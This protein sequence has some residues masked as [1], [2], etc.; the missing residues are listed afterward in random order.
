M[1]GRIV[2]AGVG[3]LLQVA[4]ALA[5]LPPPVRPM[6]VQPGPPI[7]NPGATA[8]NAPR[9]LPPGLMPAPP[10]VHP[11]PTTPGQPALP[12]GSVMR[13]N[14]EVPLPQREDKLPIDAGNLTLRR[15]NNTWQVWAGQRVFRDVGDNEAVGKEVIR[16]VRDL[17]PNE[18]V[19]IGG[20]RP[21]VEYGLIQGRPSVAAG[22]PQ[23]VVPIDLATARV[24]AVKGVWCLRDDDSILFNFGGKRTDADQAL[25]VVRKYGF[26]RIG[27]IGVGNAA[28][29]AM[30]YFF[31]GPPGEHFKPPLGSATAM[32]QEAS[33]TRTGI[34]VPGL[35]YV[36]E[37]V[38]IDPKKVEVRKD[39]T[40]W[41]VA[42][43]QDIFG[44]FGPDEWAA[45]DA[46]RTVRDGH[47]TEFCR[48]GTAGLTFFLVN[49]KPPTKV[50]FVAEGRRF[51]LAELRVLPI[52]DKW[53]VT[54]SGKHVFTVSGPDE[55]EH[56]VRL[57]KHYQFDQ[58]CHQGPNPRLGMTFL[59]KAGR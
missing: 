33:L 19:G 59:S 51:N 15:V 43:G 23:Q 29:P 9:P 27:V 7:Q 44:H 14:A 54:E 25:A 32:V 21:V 22:F 47:F 12:D 57:L 10:A 16:L 4:P 24:E 3:V 56:L 30:T 39:G 35:G 49:G 37:M 18:W 28:A 50:P 58:L 5:Q 52:G 38:K 53:A 20:P 40:E 55:G 13:A 36:G 1:R 45:R 8:P 2:A 6:Q 17:K 26:N 42:F 46:A 41:V 11:K 34:P 31:V 48:F